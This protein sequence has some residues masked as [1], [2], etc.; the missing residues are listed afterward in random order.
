MLENIHTEPH[1]V[2]E[3][4]NPSIEDTIDDRGTDLLSTGSFG[5]ICWNEDFLLE[6]DWTS[7]IVKEEK[8]E[9]EKLE[10]KSKIMEEPSKTLLE[11]SSTQ[12]LQPVHASEVSG[13]PNFS[14]QPLA[15]QQEV[16]LQQLHQIL[17]QQH[18][19][20]QSLPL[21]QPQGSGRSSAQ[22]HR[23]QSDLNLRMQQSLQNQQLLYLVQQMSQAQQQAQ[24]QSI[25]EQQPNKKS[26]I[27]AAG[28]AFSAL[29]TE[30]KESSPTSPNLSSP[31]Q[32]SYSS[33]S[34]EE[35][36]SCSPGTCARTGN[37]GTNYA[38]CALSHKEQV[39]QRRLERNR[40]TARISRNRRKQLL[41][42]LERQVDEKNA[43]NVKLRE[44]IIT[45]A[46]EN[47]AMKE[48]L[49]FLFETA[50]KSQCFDQ[51][52]KFMLGSILSVVSSHD[53]PAA[54][55]LPKASPQQTITTQSSPAVPLTYNFPTLPSS[56]PITLPLM[57]A[58]AKASPTTTAASCTPSISLALPSTNPI[59]NNVSMLS[60]PYFFP[61]PFS[62]MSA[63]LTSL[64]VFYVLI[65]P[66][67]Q[68]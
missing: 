13:Q 37:S 50:R 3:S 11:K 25:D 43:E 18:Q 29:G 22:Q 21:N 32:L 31:N 38:S 14:L 15:Q 7:T 52:D 17:H 51:I 62:S 24:P 35:D 2:L 10:K 66:V 16:Y 59:S 5:D 9:R 67:P 20:Q 49:A 48:E 65:P 8:D 68:K 36:G 39:R 57:P 33:N 64:P 26:K 45:V 12:L 41:E 61:S 4:M 23:A 53:T 27:T 63:P 40:R 55:A 19:L 34:S 6:N 44:K 54:S 42:Q 46:K 60:S 28:P 58:Q 56:I 30:S 47:S 1:I